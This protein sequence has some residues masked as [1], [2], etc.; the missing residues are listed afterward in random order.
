MSAQG[1]P[2]LRSQDQETDDVV[3]AAGRTAG[4][5]PGIHN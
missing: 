5:G 4:I 2:V 3:A 1:N